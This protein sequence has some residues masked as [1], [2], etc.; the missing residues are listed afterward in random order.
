MVPEELTMSEH[1]QKVA[2]INELA[3]K[4]KGDGLTDDEK[5]E[6]QT[7]RRWYIDACKASLQC[8]LDNIRY[9]DDQGN[10]SKPTE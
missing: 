7:L 5:A 4:A 6:Q 3:R 1:D 8:H 10:V 9:V 2:R